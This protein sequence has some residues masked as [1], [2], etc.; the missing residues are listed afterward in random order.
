[1]NRCAHPA[2]PAALQV[3]EHLL[4]DLESERE[5]IFFWRRFSGRGEEFE[6]ICE[7]CGRENT[8]QP[9]LPICRECADRLGQAGGVVMSTGLPTIR[10]R[11][12]D[13]HFSSSI[14]LPA[15]ALPDSVAAVWP[16]EQASEPSWLFLLVS[17]DIFRLEDGS[18]DRSAAI[19]EPVVPD[20]ATRSWLSGELTSEESSR[21]APKVSEA[22]ERKKALEAADFARAEAGGTRRIVEWSGEAVEAMK[23]FDDLRARADNDSGVI[24]RSDQ[25]GRYC[26]VCTARGPRRGIVVDLTS[27]DITMRLAHRSHHERHSRFPVAF[28]SDGDRPLL[29][30]GTDWNRLDISDPATGELLTQRGPTGYRAGEQRPL[31]YLDYFHAGLTVSPDSQFVAEDGWVWHPFGVVRSW[32]LQRWLDDNP[33]EAEDGLTV[34]SLCSREY[35]W[36][37]P[38]CWLNERTLAVY[39]FGEDVDLVIPAVRVFD[40]TTGEESGWFPGPSGNIDSDGTHLFSWDGD[41]TS[42]WDP[43]AG[44]RLHHDSNLH[45][46]SLHRSSRSFVSIGKDRSAVVSQIAL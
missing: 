35:Y 40:V 2:S 30:H 12:R 20:V 31:H 5:H 29:V 21:L 32:S 22:D 46:S 33:W 43:V 7:P 25:E 24:F 17:G 44:E 41:G 11:W 4:A 18:L 28:F 26:A 16:I 1:M 45:P 10:E 42:V 38:L 36:D 27:G 39:G 8:D 9:T 34:R 13:V 3:C 23:L 15:G 14:V 6:W 37:A 19:T